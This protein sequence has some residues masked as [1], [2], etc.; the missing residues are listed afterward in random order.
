MRSAIC[1]RIFVV[2]RSPLALANEG[3]TLRAYR[4]ESHEVENVADILVGGPGPPSVPGSPGTNAPAGRAILSQAVR[5][6][7]ESVAAPAVR[8]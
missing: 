2:N 4:C 8:R 1:R 7:G 5:K 6:D 3:E